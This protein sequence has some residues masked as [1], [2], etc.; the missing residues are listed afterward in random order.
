MDTSHFIYS[1]DKHLGYF[2]FLL[3]NNIAIN[4][5]VQVLVWTRVNLS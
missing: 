1:V 4:M 2:Y 3:M 5:C